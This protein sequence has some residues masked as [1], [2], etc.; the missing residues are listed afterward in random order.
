MKFW[1]STNLFNL[2]IVCL[3][4][5]IAISC[6]EDPANIEGNDVLFQSYIAKIDYIAD[7]LTTK[8]VS[9][10][11]PEL[12]LNI[13]GVVIGVWSKNIGFSYSV[14]KGK[15]DVSSGRKLQINDLF[16]IGS[17]TKPFVITVLLQLVDEG[18]LSLEDKLSKYFPDFP[19]ASNVTIKMLCNMSSGIFNYAENPAFQNK[20]NSSP[21]T[22]WEP[23]DLI[24]YA[25]DEDFYFEPGSGFHYSNTNTCFVGLI[26]EKLTGNKLGQEIKTRILDELN[27]KNTFFAS[28]Q[29]FPVGYSYSKGYEIENLENFKPDVTEKYSQTWSWAAGAMISNLND[30][31]IW[32]EALGEGRLISANMQKERMVTVFPCYPGVPIAEKLKYGLGIENFVGFWGHG[33]D[34]AGYHTFLLYDPIKKAGVVVLFNY[35]G[36]ALNTAYDIIKILDPAL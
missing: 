21:L 5:F 7:S 14:A 6:K 30:L 33:G 3:F 35:T 34:I 31:M 16:R 2:L 23:I 11:H 8:R 17:M 18:K 1:K 13:P 15:A 20:L 9:T 32:A 10:E 22:I 24:N 28:D 26:I 4:V 12:D 27:L 36:S 19:N 25:K 29:Y